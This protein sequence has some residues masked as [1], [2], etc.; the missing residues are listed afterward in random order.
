[1]LKE[2]NLAPGMSCSRETGLGWTAGKGSCRCSTWTAG[3]TTCKCRNLF[4]YIPAFAFLADNLISIWDGWNKGL[5]NRLTILAAIFINR[6]FFISLIIVSRN[7]RLNI[8]MPYKPVN[9]L[10]YWKSAL[11]KKG[12]IQ[13]L[14]SF[15]SPFQSGFLTSRDAG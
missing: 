15:Q 5:K 10:F 12:A 14:I 9:P 1:M 11:K 13:L 2:P 4:F 6:H 8:S 7:G 3:Q